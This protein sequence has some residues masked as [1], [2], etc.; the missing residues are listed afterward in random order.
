MNMDNFWLAI[1]FYAIAYIAVV[2]IG[3][4][5]AQLYGAFHHLKSKKKKSSAHETFKKTK[6]WHPLYNL[7]LFTASA[8][9]LFSIIGPV[10]FETAL[11][12]A[13]LWEVLT[14]VID[15]VGWVIIKHPWSFR[16]KE[17][18]ADYQPWLAL[19]YLAIYASP[20]LAYGI[21]QIL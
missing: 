8:V 19:I 20:L 13:L 9:G 3:V 12:T 1:L 4:G 6:P 16:F 2:L 10:S 11:A 17:F 15:L 7:I 5:H 21:L 18:Y 14:I